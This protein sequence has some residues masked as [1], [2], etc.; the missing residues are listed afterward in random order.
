M[1]TI[2][3]ISLSLDT[4]FS[5]TKFLFHLDQSGDVSLEDA[6]LL[7]NCVVL[8]YTISLIEPEQS[9]LPRSRHRLMNAPRSQLLRLLL[10]MRS[11]QTK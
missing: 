2:I 9:L 11:A 1:V 10:L 8:A 4:Y 3:N 5:L 7:D 6:K